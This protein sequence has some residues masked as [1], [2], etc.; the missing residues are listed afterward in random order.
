V[1]TFTAYSG[2]NCMR[3][4]VATLLQTTPERIP[5]PADFF[6]PVHGWNVGAYDD[7]LAAATGYR[8]REYG[9]AFCPPGGRGSMRRWIAIMQTSTTQETGET[10]AILCRGLQLLWDSA[11]I[12]KAYQPG[13]LEYG[14]ELVEA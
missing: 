1:T 2:I 12:F 3:A 5:D 9:P 6:D 14:F 11:D 10:H 13:L 4:A 8:L 7:A